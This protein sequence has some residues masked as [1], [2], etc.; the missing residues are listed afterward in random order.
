MASKGARKPSARSAAR[1][2]TITRES[3]VVRH[4]ELIRAT[5]RCL[6]T[7]GPVGTSVRA[8]A[9]E[10]GVS[11]GL[12]T[13]H[14]GGKRELLVGAYAHLSDQ[15]RR[16]EA[17]ALADAGDDPH[18]RLMA[19]IG[20][21]FG[22]EFLDEEYITARFLFWGLARTDADVARVHD[23]IYSSYRRALAELIEAAV[24]PSPENARLGFALSALLDGLW[25]E[26]CLDPRSFDPADMMQAC[27][28]MIAGAVDPSPSPGA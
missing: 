8:I 27:R 12:V 26:W 10:A 23:E 9:K 14:F 11:P 4:E 1:T 28:R 5:L 15:M 7:L 18:E 20:V 17:R 24:G 6:T 25:L 2:R 3:P 19:F 21:G 16:A 22:P 13:Y